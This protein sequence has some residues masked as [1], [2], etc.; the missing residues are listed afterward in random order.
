MEYVASWSKIFITKIWWKYTFVQDWGC[1]Q[2]MDNIF[3]IWP[4]TCE[5]SGFYTLFHTYF[6]FFGQG[7]FLLLHTGFSSALV[8]PVLPQLGGGGH[9]HGDY[10]HSVYVGRY[11]YSLAEWIIYQ[12]CKAHTHQ[13]VHFYSA[14]HASSNVSII[15]HSLAQWSTHG[16]SHM[17]KL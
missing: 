6:A 1:P 8:V 9:F 11:E 3:K 16:M 10:E 4:W 14:S 15:Q 5:I 13:V 17:P 7:M 2:K 12:W